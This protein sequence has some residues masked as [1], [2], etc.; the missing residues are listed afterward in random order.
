MSALLDSRDLGAL[1]A[2]TDS[3]NTIDRTFISI[4]PSNVITLMNRDADDVGCLINMGGE[5][6][7]TQE[8]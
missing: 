8:E 3:M 5:W 2:I 1:Q 7:F 6:F 4:C